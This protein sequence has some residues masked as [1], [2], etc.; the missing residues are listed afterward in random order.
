[1]N[2][3]KQKAIQCY[4]EWY[5]KCKR[6]FTIQKQDELIVNSVIDIA[7]QE[8]KKEVF[9]DLESFR[10]SLMKKVTSSW[11]YIVLKKRHLNSTNSNIT[12]KESEKSE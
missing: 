9:D 12:N 8:A 10:D 7:I 11:G 1:M 2:K 6:N 3:A 5:N 4:L